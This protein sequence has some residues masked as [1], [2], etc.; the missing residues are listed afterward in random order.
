MDNEEI[1]CPSRLV[2]CFSSHPS[3]VLPHPTFSR[4][5]QN[6]YMPVCLR[7][8]NYQK[9]LIQIQGVGADTAREFPCVTS[10]A[11]A[12]PA[13]AGAL[14]PEFGKMNMKEIDQSC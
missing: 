14:Y 12:W 5:L 7:W 6:E 10:S 8:D 13:C 3:L 2:D 1:P 9:L 11:L 4:P